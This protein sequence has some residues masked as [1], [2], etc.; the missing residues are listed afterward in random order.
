MPTE[1]EIRAFWGAVN[2]SSTGRQI[3][4]PC[5]WPGRIVQGYR[6]RGRIVCGDDLA[7]A[8]REDPQDVAQEQVG[9][10][11]RLG[12]RGATPSGV[13]VV[14]GT[15]RRVRD[16]RR[17]VTVRPGSCPACLDAQYAWCRSESSAPVFRLLRTRSASQPLSGN[18]GLTF[19]YPILTRTTASTSPFYCRPAGPS[20]ERHFSSSST[21]PRRRLT[22]EGH[23]LDLP[24][25]VCHSPGLKLSA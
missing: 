16:L 13:M 21:T 12:P 19:G 22:S 18:S 1:A 7:V 14:M 11:G 8:S 3:L 5:A 25:K 15:L 17:R 2:G 20:R 9:R 23:G 10:I 6:R 24:A 4:D